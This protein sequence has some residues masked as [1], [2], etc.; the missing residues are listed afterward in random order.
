MIARRDRTGGRLLNSARVYWFRALVLLD[1]IDTCGSAR[2]PSPSARTQAATGWGRRCRLPFRS[3]GT[4][5]MSISL[6][7]LVVM[8]GA[9]GV[10]PR[11]TSSSGIWIPRL[12]RGR[13]F[14]STGGAR[15]LLRSM[16]SA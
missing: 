12:Y 8:V 11:Q 4:A 2:R 13:M 1:R 10:R 9:R 5:Q 3:V 6:E 14:V 7:R 16:R 15:P